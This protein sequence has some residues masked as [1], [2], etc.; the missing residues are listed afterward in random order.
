M[1]IYEKST[2]RL[3]VVFDIK[4]SSYC[5][6]CNFHGELGYK[7][8]SAKNFIP[9]RRFKPINWI[10]EQLTAHNVKVLE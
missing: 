9:I 2:K 4:D 1:Y 10:F 8:V 6:I 3:Y 5:L 7:Y